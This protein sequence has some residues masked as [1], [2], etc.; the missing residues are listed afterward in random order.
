MRAVGISHS[1]RTPQGRALAVREFESLITLQ[2]S[3]PPE[4][5]FASTYAQLAEVHIAERNT[6]E[7]R[8]T[9]EAGLA[10][11]PDSQELTDVLNS[12]TNDR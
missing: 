1:Q 3:L 10:R 11:H 8:A 9:V 7:A 4:S 12:L 6:D 5:R 2:Q